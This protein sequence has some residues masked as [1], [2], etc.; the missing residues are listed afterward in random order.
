MTTQED[1][2]NWTIIIA[3]LLASVV[4]IGII[5]GQVYESGTL[6]YWMAGVIE[7]CLFLMGVL[8]GKTIYGGYKNG[9][10]TKQLRKT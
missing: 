7:V 6:V 9:K 2:L 5:E 3:L 4:A 1:K 10:F 8:V